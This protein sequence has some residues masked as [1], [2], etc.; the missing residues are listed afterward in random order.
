ML[1]AHAGAGY[2]LVVL[3]PPKLAPGVRDVEEAR[4]QYRKLNAAAMR[5]VAPGGLLLTCSCSQAMGAGDLLRAVAAGA[6][7]AGREAVLLR[8]LGQ[9]P[10][11]PAPAAFPEGRYLKVQLVLVR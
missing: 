4:A 1:G 11:H 9:P 7:D 8:S 2:D 10:D 6:R 3:D 5:A